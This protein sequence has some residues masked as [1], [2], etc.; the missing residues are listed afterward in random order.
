MILPPYPALVRPHQGQLCPALKTSV[1]GMDLLKQIQRKA[2]KTVRGMEHLCYEE[3]LRELG[4]FNLEKRRH[5]GNVTVTFQYLE[6][7]FKKDGDGCF[8]EA[9][10]RG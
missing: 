9:Y 8:T 7:T 3:A 1:Q 5:Q 2:T 6:G 4:M 10:F